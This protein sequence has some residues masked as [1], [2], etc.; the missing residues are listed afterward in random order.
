VADGGRIAGAVLA[1]ALVGVEIAWIIRDIT[2]SSVGNTTGRWFETNVADP[3]SQPVF[4]TT[5]DGL[6]LVV[7]VGAVIA[8]R[9]SSVR[10]AFVT[11]GILTLLV[12][13]P[14]C[15][16]FAQDWTDD[17]PLRGRL[18][19]TSFFGAAVGL[20]LLAIGLLWR[21]PA[22]PGPPGSGPRAR[23]APPR[24]GWNVLTGV[25]LVA[26]ALDLIGWQIYWITNISHQV[27]VPHYY[28]A[29]L[30]GG[31]MLAVPPLSP[32]AGWLAWGTALAAVVGAA[33][34]FRRNALARALGLLVGLRMV[35]GAWVTLDL[36]H[37]EHVL[38]T[39]DKLPTYGKVEEPFTVLEAVLG[40]VLLL[41]AGL[42][43]ADRS[44]GGMPWAAPAG[45]PVPGRRPGWGP[46]AGYAAWVPPQPQGPPQG[47]PGV[48]SPQA[49]HVPQ[50]PPSPYAV[51]QPPPAGGGFGPP[52]GQPPQATPPYGRPAYPPGPP[53]GP[54]PAAPPPPSGPP[55]AP[56]AAPPPPSGP[57]SAPPAVPPPPSGPP[58]TG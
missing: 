3:R 53:A 10:G 55:S 32:P 25:V 47:A 29:M 17:Y 37:E 7:L 22:E 26:C 28:R 34:A 49:P 8:A 41:V 6:V 9:R 23:P 31:R 42:R 33:A 38:F 58:V 21:E 20:A 36:W 4:T 13:L 57:P 16:I 11:A 48:F 56:P 39:F 27:A 15:W 14:G 50:S 40:V 2:S 43:G 1:L 5:A 18:Q 30:L 35:V 45:Y 12:R 52:V 46:T 24:S 44:A 54:P 19:T 51:P